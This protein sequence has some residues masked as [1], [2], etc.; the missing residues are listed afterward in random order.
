MPYETHK[1]AAMKQFSRGETVSVEAYGGEILTRRVVVDTSNVVV[2]CNEQEYQ[3][4][5]AERREPDG[6]GFP[7]EAV[8]P[9]V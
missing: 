5:N 6:V 2:V 1:M 4:A 9:L 7:R 3:R 8:K